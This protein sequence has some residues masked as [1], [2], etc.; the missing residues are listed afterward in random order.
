M[1]IAAPTHQADTASTADHADVLGTSTHEQVVFC[2]DEAT[3]LHAIIAIHDTTLGPALGGTRFYPYGSEREALTDVLRL[4]E[5]MT[6]KAA[7]AGLAL[8]GGKAV[9]IGD[10]ATLKTPEL[11]RAYGRF[12]DSL[13]GRYFTAADVGTTADD[14]DVVGETTKYVTGS[15]RGSGDSGMSTAYGVFCSM[16][17]AAEHVWG[18]TGLTGRHVG[19]EG[20]GKVGS[21]L[22][23]L[24]LGAGA[25]VTVA[26]PS[27]ASIERVRAQ[28]PEVAVLPAVLD[29]EVDIY[30]PCAL[31]ATLTPT[32]V[33][34]LTATVVCGAANNQLLDH[35]VAGLLQQRGITWVPD[36]VANAGGLIQVASE[37]W[38]HTPDEV[39]ER[40]GD[41][42]ATV[43]DILDRAATSGATPSDVADQIVAERLTA[44][45]AHD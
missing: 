8:G 13:S 45:S 31:G 2:R 24:L 43:S 16:R 6:S 19:V 17:A 25:Q 39:R 35:A 5:G 41:I 7:A 4:S 15:N 44:A 10:P 34:R 40:V 33:P 22:V 42:A 21:H 12:V 3:G 36:F 11:L 1:T 38:E 14:L 28:H 29:A 26:D 32:S 23:E 20:V 27:T 30:A 37:I 18:P 9:I